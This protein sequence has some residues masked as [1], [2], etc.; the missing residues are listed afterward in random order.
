[1]GLSPT[2]ADVNLDFVD[3]AKPECSGITG[4][5][6]ED[7]YIFKFVLKQLA[8]VAIF[9]VFFT[10]YIL[11]GI[12]QSGQQ[13]TQN[14]LHNSMVALYSIFYLLLVRS[15]VV[16]FD[17]TIQSDDTVTLDDMPALICWTGVHNTTVV[18]GIISLALLVFVIPAYLGRRLRNAK[19]TGTLTD[20]DTREAVGWVFLRYRYGVSTWYEFAFMAR[21][22]LLVVVSMLVDGAGHEWTVLTFSIVQTSGFLA[23][24]IVLVRPFTQRQTHA[25]TRTW[26][27]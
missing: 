10:L 13:R 18:Y 15:S 14:R 5:T 16:A 21:K 2:I 26:S 25:Q 3:F 9:G 12:S 22:T 7:V 4:T 24:Q 6:P 20:N 11:V 23:L 1:V 8:F 19:L 17:C 27:Q